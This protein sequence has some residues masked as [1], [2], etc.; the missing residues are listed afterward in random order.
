M[1]RKADGTGVSFGVQTD[2]P[3]VGGNAAQRREHDKRIGVGTMSRSGATCPGC[4]TIMTMEDMQLE[5][6]SDRIGSVMTSVVVEGPHG[7]E[8]R[9]PAEEELQ[10]VNEAKDH[11]DCIFSEIPFG[12]PKEAITEDTKRN[13][14][15]V[16]YGVDQ[17]YKL[18]TL[19]QLLA[20]GTF[21]KYTRCS[22]HAMKEAGY[23][24]EWM[25]AVQGY[26][27][28]AVD[29][30]VDR[31]STVCRPDPTPTQSGVINTFSRFALPMTWDFIEGVTIQ[32]FSGGFIG[33]IEWVAKVAEQAKNFV[34]SVLPQA[35]QSSV[36]NGFNKEF[37]VIITDPPYYDAIG[38]SVLMDFFYVWL[39]R[40]LHGL[41]SEIDLAFDEQ[42]APKWIHNKN[43][44]ELIDDASRFGGDRGKSKS[45]Y[46]EGM[47]RAFRCCHKALNPTGRLDVHFISSSSVES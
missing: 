32:T 45:S 41:S 16:Q 36:I 47:C 42:L 5:G 30:L 2:V 26:L 44:G 23:P 25:E 28:M 14:W 20:L 4:N 22:R 46:E 37:D 12:L 15:C 34:K 3:V 10:T 38:Y 8:Y 29:R 11:V 6:K 43:D 18:F 40:T 1:E 27:A 19:R 31:A 17:F 21:V 39:R 9:L 33:A 24:L 7:R 35:L 13:T